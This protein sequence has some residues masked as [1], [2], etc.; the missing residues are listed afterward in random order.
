MST[1]KQ[2]QRK[3]STGS[4]PASPNSSF[5]RAP[6]QFA[7]HSAVASEQS[8]PSTQ[9]QFDNG[10]SLKYSLERIPILPPDSQDTS[11]QN[12]GLLGEA[13]SIVYD[14]LRSPGQPLAAGT[15]AFMEAR[16]GC[17]FS[18]VRI[19]SDKQAAESAKVINAQAYTVGS[20]VV[21]GSGQYLPEAREGKRLIAH[22]LSH[23]VQQQSIPGIFQ[24]KL[25]IGSTTGS[26]ELEADAVARAVMQP[27]ISPYRSSALQ[28]RRYLH[29]SSLSS[30][31]IQR[32]VKTWGGE[33]DTIKYH[34]LKKPDR[35]GVHMELMFEPNQYVDAELIGMVQTVRSTSL[36]LREPIGAHMFWDTAEEQEA[37]ESVRI[38]R[39]ESGWGTKIDQFPTQ[40]NPLYA[41]HH[42]YQADT[43]AKTPMDPEHGE[44]GWHYMH[45]NTLEEHPA[46]LID[47]PSVGKGS[48]DVKYEFE[49]TALAVKGV[50]EG[51]FYGSVKWG[52]EKKEGVVTEL[53]L[54]LVSN[55]VPSRVFSRASARWDIA[56]TSKGKETLF[57]PV[58]RVRYTNTRGVLLVRDPSQMPLIFDADLEKGTP[59]EVIDSGHGKPFNKPLKPEWWKVTVVDGIHKGKAGW[60]NIKYLSE[61][62]TL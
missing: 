39:G 19:H 42:R 50:Q 52:F 37:F 16:F 23:V 31:T 21:F 1:L 6:R 57:L 32:A 61:K 9:D 62:R 53:P 30:A 8:P 59:L 18:K 11:R 49:T 4:R 27:E 12:A 43:L 46:R 55:D 34:K 60:V 24:R 25:S 47:K 26:A 40:T 44:P 45:N 48:N 51:T 41:A 33:F 28:I 35:D 38:P 15:R 10:S 13:P 17:D 36:R 20:N 2:L 54:S 14:V 58:G 5:L 56:K 22:E 7:P 29:R 3:S